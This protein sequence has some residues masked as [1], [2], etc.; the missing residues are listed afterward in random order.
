MTDEVTIAII[1]LISATIVAV[2]GFIG[3][4]ILNKHKSRAEELKEA[5][6]QQYNDDRDDYFEK[7]LEIIKQQ[8]VEHNHYA[9]KFD[10]I[11]L[12]IV[13]MQKDIDYL[14]KDFS[15]VVCQP[16]SCIKD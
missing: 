5:K 10:D 8:L 7:Q 16:K 4:L 12:K 15:N 3:N 2:L 6:R 14:R 1:S 9:K 11:D 13:A